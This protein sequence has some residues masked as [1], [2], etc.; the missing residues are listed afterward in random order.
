MKNPL[1]D[2]GNNAKM[3][4]TTVGKNNPL[5]LL[6]FCP[7]QFE[8]ANWRISGNGVQIHSNE[9]LEKY[10]YAIALTWVHEIGHLLN[11]C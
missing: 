9:W 10:E 1:C 6:T 2:E 3:A 7:A 8:V 4:E 11:K 5:L